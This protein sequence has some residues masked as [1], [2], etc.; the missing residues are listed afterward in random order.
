MKLK[1]YPLD[2]N[3]MVERIQAYHPLAIVTKTH[4]IW[5][6]IAVTEITPN[7]LRMLRGKRVAN[8]LKSY[9]GAGFDPVMQKQLIEPIVNPIKAP[10]FGD[11]ISF[12][13]LPDREAWNPEKKFNYWDR[14]LDTQIGKYIY[15][16]DEL[17]NV[18]T[19][20]VLD[21]MNRT[22]W[23]DALV[24]RKGCITGDIIPLITTFLDPN[25][26]VV[27]FA[28]RFFAHLADEWPN[29]E[30][31]STEYPEKHIYINNFTQLREDIFQKLK[32]D[33]EEHG[34][35]VYLFQAGAISQAF[36]YRLFKNRP[37]HAYLDIG[38]VLGLWGAKASG[39]PP[40]GWFFYWR[41]E[42]MNSMGKY[43]QSTMPP[44]KFKILT[45]CRPS[46]RNKNV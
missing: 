11:C 36:I 3:I 45:T 21:A 30:F 14:I 2:I 15:I 39:E 7:A 16:P 13:A 42:I 4:G 40:G 22:R 27:I 25:Q 6:Y 34:Y 46:W 43:L 33:T 9:D 1:I 37:G 18:L 29:T 17:V 26:R 41:K 12:T 20:G 24:F 23:Y 19:P 32:K 38:R 10:G 8:I 5:D 44:E 28:P 31:I 35:T